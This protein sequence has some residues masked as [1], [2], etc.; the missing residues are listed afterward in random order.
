MT[1]V[2]GL[3]SIGI[4]SRLYYDPGLTTGLYVVGVTCCRRC[5]TVE[6]VGRFGHQL[7]PSSHDTY[8]INHFFNLSVLLSLLPYIYLVTLR[9]V[10]HFISLAIL[11][12]SLIFRSFTHSFSGSPFIDILNR[13]TRGEAQWRVVSESWIDLQTTAPCGASWNYPWFWEG[14]SRTSLCGGGSL[15]AK[16]GLFRCVF[17]LFSKS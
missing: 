6:L 9:L 11:S 3:R 15:S 1:I 10:D 13:V 14:Q 12:C 16:A 17:S 7:P 8:Y 4:K 5:Q 2:E